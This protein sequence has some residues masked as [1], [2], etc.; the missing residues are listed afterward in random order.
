MTEV[1]KPIQSTQTIISRETTRLARIERKQFVS[2]L[3]ESF[4][5][6]K[7]LFEEALSS[8]SRLLDRQGTP[9][10]DVDRICVQNV[11]NFLTSD[12][13]TRHDQIKSLQRIY[14]N[15][16]IEKPFLSQTKVTVGKT[17]IDIDEETR[18]NLGL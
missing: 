17:K 9:E 2:T 8:Y 12:T 15:A 16:K 11:V 14:A 5:M 4:D 6:Q 3:E 1:F 10:D 18:L 7:I 13:G